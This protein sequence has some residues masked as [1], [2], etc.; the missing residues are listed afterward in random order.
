MRAC[1]SLRGRA[2]LCQ[3]QVLVRANALGAPIPADLAPSAAPSKPTKLAHARSSLADSAP[4]SIQASMPRLAAMMRG[5]VC[6][7]LWFAHAFAQA[8]ARTH[9]RPNARMRALVACV[10]AC[11]CLC[12]VCARTRPCMRTCLPVYARMLRA[13]RFP[14]QTVHSRRARQPSHMHPRYAAHCPLIR[15]APMHCACGVSRACAAFT[16][17][18]G[19]E[20]Y[21]GYPMACHA[22]LHG[23]VGRP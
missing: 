4:S 11:V 14:R 1:L 9:M 5:R 21:A 20:Q 13:G 16:M 8:C 15:T 19:T 2:S 22:A 3:P 12:A 17:A 18:L 6:T 10:R 7:R 23:A